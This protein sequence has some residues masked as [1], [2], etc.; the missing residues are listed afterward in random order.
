MTVTRS[1]V[2]WPPACD[3]VA[4]IESLLALPIV[5]LAGLL[6]LQIGLV[7]HA[8]Q[9]VMHAATE[10]VRAGALG[11]AAPQAIV[12][13]FAVGLTP[14]LYGAD[15]ALEHQLNL[16]R[17]AVHLSQ[18]QAQ[19]WVSWR[20][21]SPTSQSFDDW[22]EAA[23]DEAGLPIADVREIP[24]DNPSARARRME[25][26]SGRLDTPAARLA[27]APV[28]AA[29]G[30]TLADANLLKV[31]FTYGVA[32][33]VPLAGRLGAWIM[34]V[35]DGCEE[36][37]ERR[38]GALRLGPQTAR[39]NRSWACPY[40]ASRAPD[41]RWQ[42]RWPVRVS[43]LARMQSPARH[44]GEAPQ[45]VALAPA[46]PLGVGRLDDRATVPAGVDEINPGGV[47]AESDGS[48]RRGEGFLELG[49]GV[50]GPVPG[51]CVRSAGL[52]S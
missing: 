16:Q 6:A 10:A 32:L 18:G 48:S 45:H 28:G 34:S 50:R 9:A 35:V 17:T 12:R 26:A 19:G 46:V 25:P 1:R 37:G 3:G 27:A 47:P 51:V 11:R 8:R 22:A 13:G 43:S 41:G 36:P 15:G 40:Y 4:A 52:G 7:L 20:Q 30:Q 33:T 38:L 24:T 21:L 39:L 49:G 31:E 23:L 14:W 2:G 5:L 44:A 42:P 29:S